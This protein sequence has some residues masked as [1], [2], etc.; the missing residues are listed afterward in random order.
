MC[1]PES[2]IVYS[3]DAMD[4]VKVELREELTMS[5]EKYSVSSTAAA[6]EEETIR[7]LE[8]VISENQQVMQ[9]SGKE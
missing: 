3:Q 1:D 5:V 7:R 6:S 9:E 2:L 4:N 8:G